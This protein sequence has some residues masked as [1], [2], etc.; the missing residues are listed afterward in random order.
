[1]NYAKTELDR[2]ELVLAVWAAEFARR[3]NGSAEAIV[4]GPV[5]R[6]MTESAAKS[7]DRLIE[8]LRLLIDVEFGP[9]GQDDYYV[10]WEA[11]VETCQSGGFVND[12][13]FGELATADRQVSNTRVHP[14]DA[15]DPSYSRPAWATHVC[16]YNK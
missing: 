10:T 4:D 2:K 13:G 14:S 12:D 7:A 1:M 8:A 16:W 9:I 15:L 3:M 11:F 6:L 5:L